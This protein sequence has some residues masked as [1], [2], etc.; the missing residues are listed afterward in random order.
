MRMRR[1]CEGAVN[2]TANTGGGP[3]GAPGPNPRNPAGGRSGFAARPN[4]VQFSPSSEPVTTI[5][6]PA[7]FCASADARSPASSRLSNSSGP[8]PPKPKFQVDFNASI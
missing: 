2:A 8:S 7:G 4:P 5:D 6:Q 3:D 1:L